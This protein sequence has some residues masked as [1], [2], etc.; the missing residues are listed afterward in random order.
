MTMAAEVGV[1]QGM[2]RM[3]M[4]LWSR[5]MPKSG[6]GR[7]LAKRLLSLCG[8]SLWLWGSL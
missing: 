5:T 1:A 2:R 7:A 6:S 8:L 4:L 3:K